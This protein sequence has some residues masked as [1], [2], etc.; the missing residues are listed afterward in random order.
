MEGRKQAWNPSS[1]DL[2]HLHLPP[3]KVP[4][5]DAQGHLGHGGAGFLASDLPKTTQH[6][7]GHV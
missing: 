4:P 1:D 5:P 6:C 2:A 3:W 7:V